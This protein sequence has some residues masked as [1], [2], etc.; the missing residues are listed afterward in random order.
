[1]DLLEKDMLEAAI[2]IKDKLASYAKID[3]VKNRNY[4]SL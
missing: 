2:T 1:M 3:E 4:C